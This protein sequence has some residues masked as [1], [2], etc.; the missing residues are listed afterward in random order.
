MQRFICATLDSTRL[1][2]HLSR[3]SSSQVYP[4]TQPVLLDFFLFSCSRRNNYRSLLNHKPDYK[5]R[6]TPHSNQGPALVYTFH[7]EQSATIEGKKRK[8]ANV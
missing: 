7:R 1:V 2:P 6:C 5:T 3:S 8:D 4:I